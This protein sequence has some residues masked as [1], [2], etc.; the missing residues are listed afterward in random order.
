MG[1][2]DNIDNLENLEGLANVENIVV[3]EIKDWICK[4][5]SLFSSRSDID[6]DS[7]NIDTSTCPYIVN[8]DGAVILD[9]IKLTKDSGFERELTDGR[10]VWG[11]VKGFI[12]SGTPIKSLKG[13]PKK[14]NG[15]FGCA[16]C[17]DLTSLEGA[18]EEVGGNFTCTTCKS[19]ATLKGAP[20]EV[21]GDFNCA[22]C[23]SLTSLEGAPEKVGRSFACD[24]C[25]NLTSL[26]GATKVI[27]VD[28]ICNNCPSLETL[29]GAPEKVGNL[30]ACECLKLKY[31]SC[32]PE[33]VYYVLMVAGSYNIK[34]LDEAIIK[35]ENQ[36]YY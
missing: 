17:S 15:E 16:Y 4:Y 26:K 8:C 20:K 32:G 11:E 7:L 24:Y 22:Y 14:V 36:L 6:R 12:C 29:D 27:N 34:D 5:Y 2:F 18:P 25:K 28:F 10:F 19:L 33:E 31:I 9:A 13:A 3:E 23:H 1:L 30:L 35:Y 21:G